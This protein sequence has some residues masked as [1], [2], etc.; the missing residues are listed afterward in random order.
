MTTTILC[1][2]CGTQIHVAAEPVGETLDVRVLPHTC[3]RFLV[4]EFWMSGE[5]TSVWHSDEPGRTGPDT[6]VQNHA[7]D[8]DEE[9]SLPAGEN[10][11]TYRWQLDREALNRAE[12]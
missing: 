7:K 8:A 4:G 5:V 3:Y 11:W 6:L 10:G 2:R 12:P 1:K 9:W